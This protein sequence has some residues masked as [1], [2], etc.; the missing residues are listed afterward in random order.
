MRKL[1]VSFAAI[2]AL[3]MMGGLALPI[4]VT[5]PPSLTILDGSANQLREDFNR[6]KGSVRTLFVVDPI[7]PGCLR[8]LDDLNKALLADTQDPRLQTFVVHVPVLKP[9]AKAKDVPPAAELLQNAHVR[10]YWNPSGSFG[11]DLAE[12]VNL[13]RDGKTVYAWDVWL[14]YGPEAIWT[15]TSPPKPRLLMHQ[16]RALQGSK[17]FP[18]LDSEVFAHEV[19]QL[20]AQIPPHT[21]SR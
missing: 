4:D 1:F 13:Q 17:E 3:L 7:C 12:G 11:R 20:L 5:S 2:A 14:I 6:A 21:V 9:A 18:H 19:H 15:G 16:L 8:G 10:H